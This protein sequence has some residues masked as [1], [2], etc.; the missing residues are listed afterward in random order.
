MIERISLPQARRIAL[1]AQGFGVPRPARVN[2]GHLRRTL[3]RLGL[4][5]IDSVNVLVRTH[6][7]PAFSRLGDY[8]QNLPDTAA[9]GWTRQRG[10]FEYWANEASLLQCELS[11]LIGSRVAEARSESAGG[12][13]ER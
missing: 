1:A 3:D 2:Q 10:M 12:G 9:R 7:L 4:H 13:K 5:Q 8:D 6:Y 11:Y